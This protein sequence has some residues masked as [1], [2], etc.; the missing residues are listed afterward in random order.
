MNCTALLLE[1]Q[2]FLELY[3]LCETDVTSLK[4]KVSVHRT[5]YSAQEENALEFFSS[6]AYWRIPQ[7]SC[8]PV[9]LSASGAKLIRI[10][11]NY[12]LLRNFG[13]TIIILKYL[14][15]HP[16]YILSDVDD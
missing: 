4:L 13:K 11:S 6:R 2:I 10:I 1:L 16:N 12:I 5:T 15:I 8:I 14:S 9:A 3:I 7:Q